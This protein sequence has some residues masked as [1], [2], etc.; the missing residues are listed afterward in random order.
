[1]NWNLILNVIL[2]ILLIAAIILGVLY[3]FGRKLEKKQAASQ[4]MM[5][6]A[7]QTVSI[8]VIDKK[9]LKI[10]ESGLP[11]M[12]YEQTPKYMRWAKLPI[13]KA[14][15]GPKIMTLIADERVYQVLPV[16]SE[17]K[18]V[19]SGLYI[20]D[21]KSVRGKSIQPASKKKRL[22]DKLMFWKKD[23]KEE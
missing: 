13:V 9:K 22:R 3:Y 19:I 1:M 16:K 12:V 20:T 6:A 14:K 7:K 17:A 8:L 11:K 15:V 2:W 5:E 21:L 18:V 23:K 10:K 4:S